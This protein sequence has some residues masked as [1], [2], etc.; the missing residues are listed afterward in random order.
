MATPSDH[1]CACSRCDQVLLVLHE[2][3]ASVVFTE[4]GHVAQARIVTRGKL[5][6]QR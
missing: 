6:Q 4:A 1:G 2:S 5:N 3:L